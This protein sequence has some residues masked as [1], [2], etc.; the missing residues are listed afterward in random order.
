MCRGAPRPRSDRP[1][2]CRDRA[3]PVACRVA[4]GSRPAPPPGG[5]GRGGRAA[6]GAGHRGAT[7][8]ARDPRHPPARR[9]QDRPAGARWA[10][11]DR[12]AGGQGRDDRRM[13]TAVAT[14][15][16]TRE[17]VTR[18]GALVL[19]TGGVAGGG[20]VGEPEGVIRETILGLPVEGPPIGQWLAGDPLD[21]GSLP[22]ASAGLRT[23]DAL[24]PIDP[25]R[26]EDGPLF[27]NVRVVGALLAGQ[28]VMIERCGDGVALASAWRAAASSAAAPRSRSA[29][30]APGGGGAM[31]IAAVVDEALH[32]TVGL[33]TDECLKCNIC[34]EVCP[35]ARVDDRFPGR[36]TWVRRRSVSA[37][38]RRCRSTSTAC[39]STR[40]TA[41]STG[42]PAAAGARPPARRGQGRRGQQPRPRLDAGRPAPA[43][44]RLAD[45]PDRPA[46]EAR[47]AVH[48]ARQLDPKTDSSGRSSRSCPASTARRPCRSTRAGRSARVSRGAA[49]TSGAPTRCSSAARPAVVYFHG[50]AANYYEQHVADAAIAVLER[51]GFEVI[52]PPQECCGLPMISNGLYQGARNKARRN[53]DVLAEYARQGYRIVGTSTSCTHTLKA[54]YEEMLDVRD[55]DAD[56]VRR[57]PGISASS[58]STCTSRAAS[59]PASAGLTRSCRTTP[60]AS[61]EAMAS[62]SR[63]W[64]CSR[65]CPGCGPSTWITTAAGSRARTGSRRRS[66]TSRCAS[67]TS[68]SGGSKRAAR[69]RPRAT[70]R[71]AAGRSR[72]RRAARRG[73]R[74]PRRGLRPP[75]QRATRHRPHTR[76]HARPRRRCRRGRLVPRLG[77][78]RRRRETTL[79]RRGFDGTP[80][81]VAAHGPARWAPVNVAVVGSVAAPPLRTS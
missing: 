37:S 38:P 80:G 33:S 61:S 77:G 72:R 14:A 45:Q 4:G 11:P 8:A 60:R 36:S 40:R 52:A 54:E 25:A 41:P 20:L 53:V 64:T 62:G 43:A 49:D 74:D 48:A 68:C 1:R 55:G 50:C 66:T 35:V 73:G 26:P 6:R 79:V 81:G 10:D 57:R 22:I 70:R 67:A 32:E 59:T 69:P 19:A 3:R 30:G 58:C 27:D 39:R 24:R 9:A 17:L 63:R 46:R 12:R 15:A 2:R 56:A 71:R 34:N 21:P 65:W 5:P 31:T 29:R 7:R 51:N 47:R 75:T 13:V 78:C 28:R 44:S 23:D 42:A 16:A 18:V 76:A